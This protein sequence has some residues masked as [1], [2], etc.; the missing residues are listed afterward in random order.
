MAKKEGMLVNDSE[1]WSN[2]TTKVSRTYLNRI[3]LLFDT[4]IRY[5]PRLYPWM[6][7][8][9]TNK[10]VRQT[11]IGHIMLILLELRLKCYSLGHSI[12]RKILSVIRK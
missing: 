6:I 7:N 2:K 3:F 9:I 8:V 11:G 10:I 1:Y 12:Y 4:K 5:M